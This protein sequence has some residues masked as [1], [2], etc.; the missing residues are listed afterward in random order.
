MVIRRVP[1][2]P[3]NSSVRLSARTPGR[4]SV[5]SPPKKPLA[6]ATTMSTTPTTGTAEV[7]IHT[8]V[9]CRDRGAI[10]SGEPWSGFSARTATGRTIRSATM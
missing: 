3:V 7:R 4:I 2:N 1:E 5:A 6:C 9:I 10:L 8:K